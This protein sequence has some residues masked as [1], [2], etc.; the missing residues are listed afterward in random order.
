MKYRDATYK[1]TIIDLTISK[2]KYGEVIAAMQTCN[3]IN[4]LT[5]VK[6]YIFRR[7]EIDGHVFETMIKNDRVMMNAYKDIERLAEILAKPR[8][9]M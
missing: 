9:E 5:R 6:L 7:R 4:T 1:N 2:L 3:V 8:N